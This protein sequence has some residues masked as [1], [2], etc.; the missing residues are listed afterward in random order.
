MDCDHSARGSPGSVVLGKS[1]MLCASAL[2]SVKWGGNSS[3]FLGLLLSQYKLHNDLM[4]R[5]HERH[6]SVPAMIKVPLC[7][8]YLLSCCPMLSW[9][10][11][12]MVGKTSSPGIMPMTVTL[13][14]K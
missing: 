7:N 2:P 10:E 6:L 5:A 11:G 4:H 1:L 3:Y 12:G 14:G 9:W 8:W 13:Y